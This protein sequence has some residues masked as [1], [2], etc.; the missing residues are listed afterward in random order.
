MIIEVLYEDQWIVAVH[1]P[2]NLLI[3]N[4]YYARNIRENT[5]IDLIQEQLGTSVYPVHR[6]DR[7]TS[8]VLLLAKEKEFVN[9]FQQ[10]FTGNALQKIYYG[11]VRGHLKEELHIT[12]PVKNEDTQQYKEAETLCR[13]IHHAELDI[14]VQPYSTSRYS[15]VELQP[16]TGRMHQLRIHMNKISHPLVGDT[17]YG[18]RFHNRMF[19]DE[20]NCSNLLLHACSIQFRHPMLEENI[21]LKAEIPAIW[22]DLFKVF[23]WSLFDH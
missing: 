8:G 2:A 1:K 10:L 17:K 9:P 13:T 19:A 6:L 3:H 23:N 14:P 5:L 18:D 21:L 16:L 11:I 15:L 20:F 4:S 7:K 12:S 22:E